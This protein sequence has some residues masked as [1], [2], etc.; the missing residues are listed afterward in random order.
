MADFPLRHL[1]KYVQNQRLLIAC[2]A[3]SSILNQ[4]CDLLP[5]VLLGIAIDSVANQNNSFFAGLG[6]H[7]LFTQLIIIGALSVIAWTFESLFQYLYIISWRTLAQTIQHGLRTD[8]YNHLQKL[9]ISYFEVKNTGDLLTILNDD[10]NQLER[11]FDNGINAII[12]L[13]A[14]TAITA[15]IFFYTSPYIALCTLSP[16]PF[17]ALVAWIF[18]NRLALLHTTVRRKASKLSDKLTN[19]LLGITT[20]KSYTCQNLESELF[21]QKSKNYMHANWQMTNIF[22]AFRPVMR[23]AIV[24]GFVATVVIGGWFTCQGKIPLGMYSTL[25]F[26]TQRL[27]WPFTELAE[28]VNDY[29]RSR[30]AANRV[31]QLLHEPITI[32]GGSLQLN[33]HQ[34]QGLIEFKNVT[35]TYPNGTCVLSNISFTIQAGKTIAFVGTT[36]SGKSSII[37]LLLRFYEPQ[38]GA[39]FIDSIDTRLLTLDTVCQSMSVVMQE[40]FLFNGT[41]YDNI[42]YGSDHA[43]EELVQQAARVA[44]ADTFIEHL[45][46]KYNFIVGERGQKLSGGQK[47]RISIARAILKNAPIFIFDEATSAVDND[48]EAAIHYSITSFAPNRTTILIAHRLAT[49]YHADLIYVLHK[50]TI[51][52]SGNHQALVAQQ[53]LYAHLW[54]LQTGHVAPSAATTFSQHNQK[55]L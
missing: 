4:L 23:M 28:I 44:Q 3:V 45:P 39:I 20:I 13:V 42:A 31:L 7:D 10:V 22:A 34:V 38:Q 8:A 53:G 21:I 12:Q 35:F 40:P 19:N 6:F 46:N 41:I 18:Q 26:L 50:G 9:D 33:T 47:Q 30:A 29:R 1:F 25:I 5:E 52:E 51:V 36:G 16:T 48:T 55:L 11:F 14:S 43:T 2:A 17:I 37:K 49:I 15:A 32:V 27:L 24:L 54:H